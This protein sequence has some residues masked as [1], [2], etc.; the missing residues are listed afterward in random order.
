MGWSISPTAGATINDSGVAT[1]T[2]NGTYT[3]TYTDSNG[4]T[5]ST[6]YTANCGT[7]PTNVTISLSCSLNSSNTTLTITANA[8]S[9]VDTAVSVTVT[10]NLN[11]KNS[12]GITFSTTLT[13]TITIA[14]GSSSESDSYDADDFAGGVSF[15]D[16]SCSISSLSPT[17]SSSQNYIKGSGCSCSG[18]GGTCDCSGVDMTASITATSEEGSEGA[19]G[20]YPRDC[21]SRMSYTAPNWVTLR[22]ENGGIMVDHKKNTTTSQRSGTIE[23]K[24]DGTVCKTATITQQAGGGGECPYPSTAIQIWLTGLTNSYQ[25]YVLTDEVI[26]SVCQDWVMSNGYKYDPSEYGA[27]LGYYQYNGCTMTDYDSGQS[28]YCDIA[29]PGSASC[30]GSNGRLS[31]NTSYHLYGF[32][33]SGFTEIRTIRMPDGPS[34]QAGAD[35]NKQYKV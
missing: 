32:N 17:S 28:Y 19:E 23:I 13:D 35:S 34:A 33:G 4:C 25:Y 11:L 16:A 27:S 20:N 7:G 1:F 12:G 31:A 9:N 30:N 8:S 22:F 6:T 18:G 26:G 2:A 10:G 3:I 24:M 14:A 15:V 5:G 21:T 29:T